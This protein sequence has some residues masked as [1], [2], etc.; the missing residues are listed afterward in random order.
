MR[1]GRERALRSRDL[2]KATP[3][4]ASSRETMQGL[5]RDCAEALAASVESREIGETLVG[6]R[7]EMG[8][9]S[10]LCGGA[11]GGV[12]LRTRMGTAYISVELDILH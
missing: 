6:S 8:G 4:E 7:A 5:S 2:G 9:S 12:S 1:A 10:A 11:R 3:G